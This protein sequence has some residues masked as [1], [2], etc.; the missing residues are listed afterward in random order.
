[1]PGRRSYFV[2]ILSEKLDLLSL[3]NYLREK[4]S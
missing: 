3:V 2:K 4:A 1:M